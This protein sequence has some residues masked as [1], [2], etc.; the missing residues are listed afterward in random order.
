MALRMAVEI[1]NLCTPCSGN[2]GRGAVLQAEE[3]LGS[4]GRY[5]HP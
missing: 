3:L 5:R 2:P 4:L 1:R